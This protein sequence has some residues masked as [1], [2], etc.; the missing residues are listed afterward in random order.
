MHIFS[1]TPDKLANDQAAQACVMLLDLYVS[2]VL[3][4]RTCG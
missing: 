3:Q 4:D 2:F 1:T